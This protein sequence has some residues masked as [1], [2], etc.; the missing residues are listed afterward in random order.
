[1]SDSEA[2]HDIEAESDRSSDGS[3]S[4]GSLRHFIVSEGEGDSPATDY[5]SADDIEPDLIIAGKRKRVERI[6]DSPL[7]DTDPDDSDYVE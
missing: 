5:D 2:S 4:E 6:S 1:M 3:D 7:I